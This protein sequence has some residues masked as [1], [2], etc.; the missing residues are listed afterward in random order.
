MAW[1]NLTAILTT[2]EWQF[3]QTTESSSFRISHTLSQEP[4][5]Y[6]GFYGLIALALFRNNQIEFFGI[7][8]LYPKPGIDRYQFEA[9][10]DFGEKRIAIRGQR[11]YWSPVDWNVRVEAWIP[12]NPWEGEGA[13]FYLV[14]E[15]VFYRE[16]PDDPALIL[17]IFRESTGL[18]SHNFEVGR[19]YKVDSNELV[20]DPA[21]DFIGSDAIEVTF[22]GLEPVEPRTLRVAI[23]KNQKN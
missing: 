13:V 11:R 18:G 16:S 23:I 1:R 4:L 10:V 5:R 9:P 15:N 12:E 8:R 3:S 17:S 7:R 2:R 14:L 19:F 20:S 22:T 6:W 21:I